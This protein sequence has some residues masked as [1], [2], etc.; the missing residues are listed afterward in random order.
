MTVKQLIECLKTHDQDAIVYVPSSLD[1]TNG[2]V[3]FVAKVP[4]VNISIPGVTI[5]DDV[6]LLPG[7]M[8]QF[9]C[10]GDSDEERQG[11]S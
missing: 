7:E 9:V 6:A 8:E 2:T 11:D 3:Q 10:D 1:G 5:T 4:H